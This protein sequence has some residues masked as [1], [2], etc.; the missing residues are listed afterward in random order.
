MD[1]GV[2]MSG[3]ILHHARKSLLLASLLALLSG[4]AVIAQTNPLDDAH[5]APHQQSERASVTRAPALTPRD[6]PLRVDVNLVL[7]PVTVTDALG[8]PVLDLP[9]NTF[10]LQE[11]G[12]Q[13]P[14]RYFSA[15]DAPISV[16]LVVD[17]SDSMKNK[18]E[19]V[20]Q[21]VQEFFDNANPADDYFVITV[22][23]KPQVIA[24]S[25]DSVDTILDRLGM[26]PPKGGTAL[27]DAIYLGVAKLRAAK[28]KRK[29]MVVISDGGDNRSRYTFKEI[30]SVV[31]EADVLTYGIGI[32]DDMPIPLLKTIEERMGRKWLGDITFASGGRTVAADDRRKIPDIAA[33]VSRELRNQYVLGYTSSNPAKDGHWR[34]ISVQLAPSA[35][36][37]HVHYKEGYLAATQ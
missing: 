29:A 21:A 27:F 16:A 9:A 32:F 20:K 37:K 34:K 15:E 30:K 1:L 23:N 3:V 4:S 36:P 33:M 18:I 2:R 12:V 24:A 19:Y 22:S 25:G 28:Y 14:V 6:Q 26:T 8:R 17:F 13:Q 5:V 35:T 31:S 11:D 10:S 7:V